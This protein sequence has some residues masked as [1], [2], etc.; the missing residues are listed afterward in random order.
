MLA[1]MQLIQRAP[2]AA[3][4]TL[5]AMDMHLGPSY[6]LVLA[7]DKKQDSSRQVLTDLQQRFLPRTILV[8]AG[9]EPERATQTASELSAGKQMLSES[10]TLYICEGFT[11]QTPAQGA[12]EI[13]HALD[14]LR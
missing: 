4:Q 6:E 11:C 3:A 1:T 10:P 9:P 14:Q 12:V 7:C 5:L 13:E 8:V 2:S